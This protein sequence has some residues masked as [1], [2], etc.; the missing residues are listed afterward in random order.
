[1]TTHAPDV[2]ASLFD[3]VRKVVFESGG[4]GEAWFVSP[5]AFALATRFMNGETWFT[6]YRESADHHVRSFYHNQEGVC[7]TDRRECVPGNVDMII[8][9]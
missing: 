5:D 4:D 1:M 6:E 3:A 7:F 8:Q 9:L 2:L